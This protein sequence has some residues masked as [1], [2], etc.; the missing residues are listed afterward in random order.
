[1][2]R[3]FLGASYV[4]LG[5]YHEARAEIGGCAAIERSHAEILASLGYLL[6]RR[7]DLAGGRGVLDEL[8]QLS[9]CAERVHRAG[10]PRYT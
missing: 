5:R 8:R 3:A 4:E 1:M 7:G 10:W 2:A 6:G 9:R